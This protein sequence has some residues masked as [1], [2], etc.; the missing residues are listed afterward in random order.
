MNNTAVKSMKPGTGGVA[1]NSLQSISNERVVNAL[2]EL[3]TSLDPKAATQ[4]EEYN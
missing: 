4:K 3:S 1:N 2:N